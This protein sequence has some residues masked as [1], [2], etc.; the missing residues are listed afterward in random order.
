MTNPHKELN[1]IEASKLSDIE[2]KVMVIR[3]VKELK[4]NYIIMKKDIQ[5]MNKNHLE[6]K[7]A[8]SI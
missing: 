2:F 5:M 1:E 8:I 7:N 6:M 4:E 3:I